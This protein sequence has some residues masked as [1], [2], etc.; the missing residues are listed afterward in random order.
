[1]W[2]YKNVPEGIFELQLHYAPDGVQ[3]Y[4]NVACIMMPPHQGDG[5]F[6]GVDLPGYGDTMP[7]WSSLRGNNYLG[8]F[9]PAYASKAEDVPKSE[10]SGYAQAGLF[11]PLPLTY[12]DDTGDDDNNGIKNNVLFVSGSGYR[13]YT[14]IDKAAITAGE[15]SQG[16][17]DK[18]IQYKLGLGNYETGDTFTYVRQYG[19]VWPGPQFWCPNIIN[20]YDGN[21]YRLFRYADAILM[22]AECYCNLEDDVN[23]IY[24]L[25]KIRN[26]AGV[27]DY[28]TFTGFE[29]LLVELRAERARELGGELQRKYDLVRWGIWYDQTY[30][31]TKNGTMKANMRPCHRY[32]PIPDVECSLSKGALSNPEYDEYY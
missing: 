28:P 12:C 3:Y 30:K 10:Q 25:N 6:N 27:G 15:N 2:R 19:V 14:M 7:G 5:I 13:Y 17:I 1:M 23:A 24:Y 32:Y 20:T 29:D 16:K 26:R 9:R 22:L 21:N 8:I 4:G 11:N 31:C 18:R